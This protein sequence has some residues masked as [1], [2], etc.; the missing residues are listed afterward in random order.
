MRKGGKEERR[1]EGREKAVKCF[2]ALFVCLLSCR[3]CWTLTGLSRPRPA[4]EDNISVSLRTPD[5][6]LLCVCVC[7]FVWYI[8]WWHYYWPQRENDEEEVDEEEHGKAHT[9]NAYCPFEKQLPQ[10]IQCSL[11]TTTTTTT[12]TTPPLIKWAVSS[13]Y[14]FSFSCSARLRTASHS[15]A[16]SPLLGCSSLRVWVSVAFRLSP[17]GDAI[18]SLTRS[19]S[20]SSSSSTSSSPPLTN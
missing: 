7:V 3:V 11:T 20:S 13:S 8:W 16:V 18:L 19:S 1:K 4:C 2:W 10:F 6:C 5:A 9:R 12:T 17:G 15:V 14:S